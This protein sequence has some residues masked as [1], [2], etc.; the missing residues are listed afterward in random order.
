MCKHTIVTHTYFTHM[1]IH[2]THAHL[3]HAHKRAGHPLKWNPKTAETWLA[4]SSMLR[5][6]GER[7]AQCLSDYQLL[8]EMGAGQVGASDWLMSVCAAPLLHLRQNMLCFWPRGTSFSEHSANIQRTFS[9][10]SGNIQ[11]TWPRVTGFPQLPSAVT[12][13]GDH[14][15]GASSL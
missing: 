6:L 2:C 7:R 4:G 11:C 14:P 15:L 3:K 10:H 5:E 8:L 12:S 13:T 9:G 1:H